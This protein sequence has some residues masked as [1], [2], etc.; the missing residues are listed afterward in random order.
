MDNS[1]IIVVALGEIENMSAREYE[2]ERLRDFTL[3]NIFPEVVREL[4][5]PSKEAILGVLK[6]ELESIRHCMAEKE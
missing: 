1:T 4:G 2:R 3:M 6:R 5:R